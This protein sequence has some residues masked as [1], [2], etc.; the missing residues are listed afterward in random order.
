VSKSL[1]G[2]ALK[3]AGARTSWRQVVKAAIPYL[4]ERGDAEEGAITDAEDD[5]SA[6]DACLKE[7]R[8]EKGGELDLDEVVQGLALRSKEPPRDPAAVTLMTVHASKGLEFDTVY[9]VGVAE[10][11]LPSWQSTKKGDRSSEMEEERRN[12]FVAITR[13]RGKVILSRAQRYRGYLKA[14]SRFFA[15]MQIDPGALQAT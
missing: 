9:V 7:I 1:A 6:W 8:A 4:M 2:F 11:V 5:R 15:E 12:C 10:E 13:T 3:L 14:P